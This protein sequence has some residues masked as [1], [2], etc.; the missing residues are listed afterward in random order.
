MKKIHSYILA[1]AA[2]LAFVPGM[3][4]QTIEEV[5]GA[6]EFPAD[7]SGFSETANIGFKKN[8]SKPVDGTYWL[9]LEAYATGSGTE[10]SKAKPSDAILVLDLSSSMSGAYPGYASRL[11]GLQDATKK[12]VDSIY[13]NAVDALAKDPNYPGNRIAIITYSGSTQVVLESGGWVSVDETG[14]DDLKTAING[15]SLEGH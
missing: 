4:A 1:V 3:R 14:R 12:F 7:T 9:K 11:A 13:Q 5:I 8:I 15:F 6:L 2:L 10:T